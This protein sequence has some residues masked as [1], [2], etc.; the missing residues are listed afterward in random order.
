MLISR[1]LLKLGSKPFYDGERRKRTGFLAQSVSACNGKHK[2]TF[3]L[4][5]GLFFSVKK[6]VFESEKKSPRQ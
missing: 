1:D 2:G 4:A 6:K 5:T 3:F